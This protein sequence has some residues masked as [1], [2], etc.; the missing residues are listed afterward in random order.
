MKKFSFF[1]LFI[2]LVITSCSNKEQDLRVQLVDGI[3]GFWEERGITCDTSFNAVTNQKCINISQKELFLHY[4]PEQKEAYESAVKN[5]LEANNAKEGDGF[6]VLPLSEFTI[7]M[8]DHV[9]NLA[10]S[11]KD[12]IVGFTS[13]EPNRSY[14]D[15]SICG[16][17]WAYDSLQC[18]FT[19]DKMISSFDGVSIFVNM[20]NDRIAEND[21][22]GYETKSQDPCVLLL[23]QLYED[24]VLY[25]ALTD[26]RKVEPKPFETVVDDFFTKKGK[27][28]LID[29]YADEYD[30][31]VESGGQVGY[32]IWELRTSA[33][34]SSGEDVAQIGL[35][36]VLPLGDNK[37]VVKYYDMGIEGETVIT[38]AEEN[39]KLKI[40][41]FKSDS[42]SYDLGR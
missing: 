4:F 29:D 36:E 23:K 28:K 10:D 11:L 30:G 32:A 16:Y 3:I 19:V 8:H 21:I 7:V 15:P 14:P 12:Y 22:V 25:D 33:Q 1:I 39:G 26:T 42:K 27:Q 41:D 37:Y 9:V 2:L 13:L 24:Y 18:E 5:V 6:V 40:D 35:K 20:T 31:E 38:F 17:K 34:D